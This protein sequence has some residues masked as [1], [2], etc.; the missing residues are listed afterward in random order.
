MTN[1]A[2]DASASW[3]GAAGA[4]LTARHPKCHS[5][6]GYKLGV[7]RLVTLPCDAVPPPV[8]RNG[9]TSPN[10]RNGA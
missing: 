7:L 9:E 4:L 5:A 1:G 3:R 6:Q 2:L 10:A 8:R